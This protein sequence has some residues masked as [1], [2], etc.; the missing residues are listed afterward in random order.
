MKVSHSVRFASSVTTRNASTH[1]LGFAK[2]E[3][4]HRGQPDTGK[5]PGHLVPLPCDLPDLIAKGHLGARCTCGSFFPALIS[6][7][8]TSGLSGLWVL[9]FADIVSVCGPTS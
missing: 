8:A 7:S 9:R 3:Q 6:Q 5:E 4:Q 1:P 2:E